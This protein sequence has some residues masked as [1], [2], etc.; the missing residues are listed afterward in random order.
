MN[1][2]KVEGKPVGSWIFRQFNLVFNFLEFI[3]HLDASKGFC[4][5]VGME[6]GNGLGHVHVETPGQ[7]IT[8]I[9]NLVLLGNHVTQQRNGLLWRGPTEQDVMTGG[10][11]HKAKVLV[12]HDQ[13][14]F[15]KFLVGE[16]LFGNLSLARVP[17]QLRRLTIKGYLEWLQRRGIGRRQVGRKAGLATRHIF[18]AGDFGCHQSIS[19][20]RNIDHFQSMIPV[21]AEREQVEN[22]ECF[23]N[24]DQYHE[25][26]T[27]G[28]TSSQTH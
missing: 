23:S 20:V 10:H 8:H 24:P 9:L 6:S 19:S 22:E 2:Q 11:P 28:C 3:G 17:Q 1:V 7:V 26:T 13:L 16:S 5:L 4:T 25:S 21:A 14:A 18:V 15:D 27:V 12:K